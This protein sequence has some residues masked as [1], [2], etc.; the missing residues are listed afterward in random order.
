M[1][2]IPIA[3][4]R[5][6]HHISQLYATPHSVPMKNRP[7]TPEEIAENREI[8]EQRIAFLDAKIAALTPQL[9]HQL[10]TQLDK[11]ARQAF[12]VFADKVM[13]W[14]LFKA[15]KNPIRITIGIRSSTELRSSHNGRLMSGCANRK[16]S[17]IALVDHLIFAPKEVI[18]RIVAHESLHIFYQPLMHES[19][20][21]IKIQ[22][23]LGVDYREDRLVEEEWVRRMEARICGDVPHPTLWE[24]SVSQGKDDWRK[25]YPIMKK[26]WIAKPR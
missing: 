24:Y 10:T 5:S 3:S 14:K 26:V 23:D 18:H 21:S 4:L 15:P 20:S 9:R 1:P 8:E 22:T 17:F 13:Q 12:K 11:T 6:F 7:S 19:S 2:P 25:L 16:E